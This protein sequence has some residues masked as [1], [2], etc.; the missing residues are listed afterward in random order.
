[1]DY[2]DDDR[3]VEVVHKY[4]A[5]YPRMFISLLWQLVYGRPERRRELAAKLYP[6]VLIGCRHAES[7]RDDILRAFGD[8]DSDLGLNLARELGVDFPPP[9]PPEDDDDIDLNKPFF[10]SL[11]DDDGTVEQLRRLEASGEDY[12]VGVVIHGPEVASSEVVAAK[13]SDGA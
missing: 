8:L 7:E 11:S 3:L 13:D 12:D 4:A 6:S 5:A 9:E 10:D 1:M 2:L